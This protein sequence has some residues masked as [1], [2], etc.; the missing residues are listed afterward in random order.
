MTADVV[1][2]GGGIMGAS[3]A[4]HL[5]RRGCINVVVLES[6]EMFGMGSTGLNAGGIRYQFATAVNIELSKLSISMM[7]RFADEMDQQLGLKRCGYLFLLDDEADLEQFRRNVALQNA[8]DV[9]SRIVNVGEISTLAPEIDLDGIIG[10]SW[11]PRDGLVDPNGLL[12][13][14]VS[15]ARRLG[16]TLRTSAAVTAIDDLGDG[17][18]RVRV[19][20]GSTYETR[21]VVVAAGAWSAPIG[22]MVGVDLPIQPIRRQIAVTSAI[23]GLRPDFPF[24]I[25]FAQALYFHREGAGLL[26]GMSNRDEAAGYDTRVDEDWRLVHLEQAMRRLPMLGDAEIAAEWAGLYEVT[27]DDQPTLGAVPEAPGVFV[28]AGFSGHGLMHGPATGMLMA[29]E[30]LD[31]RA[32][33]IDIDPLRH[34]RFAAGVTIDASAVEYNVV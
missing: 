17:L 13:G 4:Y 20:D 21:N 26:T 9:P 8:H 2:V 28:C 16:V 33:T 30:I 1:I 23:D 27:P 6:A 10:G 25:D 31:G 12:Q 32:T 19:A 22:S 18:R 7:E 3:T 34:A 15:N 29:E 14:Y 24:V 11:C 5:A